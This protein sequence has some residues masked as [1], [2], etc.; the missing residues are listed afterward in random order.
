MKVGELLILTRI[1]PVSRYRGEPV[2]R[3]NDGAR[4]GHREASRCGRA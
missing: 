3:G 2:K 4:S 1:A